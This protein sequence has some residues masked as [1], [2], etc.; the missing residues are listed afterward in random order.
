MT[1]AMKPIEWDF[2]DLRQRYQGTAAARYS[3]AIFEAVSRKLPEVHLARTEYYLGSSISHRFLARPVMSLFKQQFLPF[4]PNGWMLSRRFFALIYDDIPLRQS[5]A[6]RRFISRMLYKN[7]LSRAKLIFTFSG[8]VAAQWNALN[9]VSTKII[10][11]PPFLFPEYLLAPPGN[12]QVPWPYVVGFGTGEERKN[13]SRTLDLF[14]KAKSINPKLKLALYG[15]SY[16]GYGHARVSEEIALRNLSDDVVHL[17]RID[18]ST[19]CALMH[20]A[21]LFLFPSLNEGIGLPPLEALAM[22][23]K[24]VVSDIPVFKDF[25]KKT[26]SVFFIKLDAPEE[27]AEMIR[28]ALAT[29]SN[30]QTAIDI[31]AQYNVERTAAEILNALATR[32]M[33]GDQ[34]RN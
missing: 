12:H 17:G 34:G 3:E 20:G 14:Q 21:E 32:G 27:D 8:S 30:P 22:G 11:L 13:I 2:S 24:V 23:T 9:D 31:R 19:L 25:L 26:D 28:L 18:D 5:S 33:S 29:P 6:L 4:H 15:G 1:G 7:W 16:R 10:V